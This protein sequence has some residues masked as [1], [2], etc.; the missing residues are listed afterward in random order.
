MF[1]LVRL[2]AAIAIASALPRNTEAAEPRS[3]PPFSA[4][5]E[6]ARVLQPKMAD[7]IP[8]SLILGNG[9]L[10][11]I[12]WLNGGRLRFSITKND[13]CDG[14]LDTSQ[15]P[16]FFRVDIANHRWNNPPRIGNPPSW[17]KP[18]PCP[19]ICGHVEFHVGNSSNTA[20][21]WTNVRRNGH[22]SLAYNEASQSATLRIEGGPGESAGWGFSAFGPAAPRRVVV[23]ISGSANAKWYLDFPGT[24]VKSGWIPARLEQVEQSFDLPVGPSLDRIDVYIWTDDGKPAEVQVHSVMTIGAGGEKINQSLDG[25][26]SE[27]RFQAELDLA[28]AYARVSHKEGGS[29]EAR[30]LYGRNVA[31]FESTLA[32][33]L[34]ACAADF[35][36]AS[37]R[38]E[39]DGTEWL[40]TDVPG[41]VDWKG[42]SFALAHAAKGSRH[43]VAVVTSLEHTD[44]VVAAVKLARETLNEEIAK[45]RAEHESAWA[46]FWAT[47][48]ISLDDRYLE[49]VWYRN[50]Y[51]LRCAS[52][53]GVPPIGLYL[54]CATDVMP[55]HG[56]ATTDYNF[57]QCFWGA[58]ACNH[59]ELAEPYN[60]F[61]VDYLPRGKW[62]AKETYDLDGAF[63]PVNHFVH[64]VNDPASCKSRNRHMNFYMPW[65]YVPGANGWQAHNVW[66]AYLYQ[67]DRT[68]LDK[69]A[70]PLVREMAEFYAGFLERCRRTPSGTAIYGP[71]YSPEHRA[72]GVDDTPCDIAWTRFTLKAAMQ[73]ARTLGRDAALV[74]RWEAALKL[75]PDYPLTPATK[76]P[77]VADMRG[78]EPIEFNV[79]VP[80]L[81]VFPVG[82]VNWF[83]PPEEKA[84]FARTVETISWTGYNS[85]MILAGARARLSLPGTHEWITRT[86]QERQKP[87]G[88]LQLAGDTRGNYTEQFAACGIVSEMLLQSVG[89][90]IR[91]FPAWPKDKGARFD[92]LRAEG[93]FVVSA[94]QHSGQVKSVTVL[95]TAG[96]LLRWVNPLAAAPQARKNGT[97]VP[98]SIDGAGICSLDTATGDMIHLAPQP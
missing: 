90:I 76:P 37:R 45:Q 88:S 98:V 40:R 61:I 74:Q 39:T 92:R 20:P 17:D 80:V 96:G 91:L 69:M 70:Y 15:D 36:P 62:F 10:N 71:S 81:P 58:Y 26:R 47:S 11:G 94:E 2:T 49:S 31:V 27:S 63:Y 24:G 72:F 54:G 85:T 42:M 50:L 48:G 84:L 79:A 59:P 1:K 32:V 3:A 38:G 28:R 6:R 68:Y 52:K 65:T 8:G 34:A 75:V 25:A 51:F 46:A 30:V 13:V 35:I 14:R 67:P 77:V 56:V 57:E 16:D 18:Y 83:S 66:L 7:G 87:N 19:L 29:V 44:P 73:G 93:G 12:L 82:E 5:L 64:Q 22:E 33:S 60:R 23:S 86:F 78:G 55:W 43:V 89:G 9:D 97:V 41:D 95:S 21:L 53:P 4:A